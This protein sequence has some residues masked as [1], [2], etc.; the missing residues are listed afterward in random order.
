MENKKTDN[1]KVRSDLI[2]KTQA[3]F[4]EIQTKRK[5]S[6]EKDLSDLADLVIEAFNSSRSLE[7]FKDMSKL[8]I[9]LAKP[10]NP[11][12]VRL[13]IAK[14]LDIKYFFSAPNPIGYNT[15]KQIILVLNKDFDKEINKII[16]ILTNGDVKNYLLKIKSDPQLKK[17]KNRYQNLSMESKITEISRLQTMLPMI[18]ANINDLSS[19]L[20]EAN[21]L[22]DY[23][24]SFDMASR[25][26]DIS[27][28]HLGVTT[29][30][31][32][33]IYD[34]FK[35][36][37]DYNKFILDI[38]N[39]ASL[40][41]S[42]SAVDSLGQLQK[43]IL[44][45]SNMASLSESFSAVDSLGQL[46]KSIL[47]ISNMASLSESFS[48]VDSLGQL[49][50]SILDISCM[51]N[52]GQ[53]FDISSRLLDIHKPLGV[54]AYI[55]ESIHDIF[56]L[57]P[58]YDRFILESDSLIDYSAYFDVASRLTNLTAW[59]DSTSY[60]NNIWLK[61]QSLTNFPIPDL[62]YIGI[63]SLISETIPF[64]EEEDFKKFEYNWLGYFSPRI[65]K[66]FYYEFKKGN[67]T[68]VK[69][70]FF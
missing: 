24:A 58:D 3:I 1:K 13:T 9:N 57:L 64:E 51:V 32:E 18:E 21:S 34:I 62:N 61:M 36:L 23:S 44:D 54:T 11:K 17:A 6:D 59:P 39:M 55:N 40:S 56:K 16:T 10:N 2:K 4:N 38:S 70:Y 20:P 60:F 12:N 67:E 50:K 42:F 47:D 33:S 49:Q 45:V 26:M 65:I 15:Y 63:T 53:S 52:L 19:L 29:H 48:A 69:K 41:E 28:E 8:I 30:I 25:F 66:K 22:I 46:Q 7:E 5:S 37:P 14:K 35:L 27:E 43:S 68:E 31:N